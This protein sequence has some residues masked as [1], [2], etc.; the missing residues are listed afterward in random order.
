M[1]TLAKVFTLFKEQEKVFWGGKL[2]WVLITFFSGASNNT[3]R[4]IFTKQEFNTAI[5]ED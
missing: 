1:I 4:K 3:V 5:K 2:W